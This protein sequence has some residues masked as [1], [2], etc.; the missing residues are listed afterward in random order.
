MR[1]LLFPQLPQSCAT[2]HCFVFRK[3]STYVF[4]QDPSGRKIRPV[5]TVSELS[6]A[7]PNGLDRQLARFLAEEDVERAMVLQQG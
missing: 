2:A 7:A 4:D 6:F 1:T 5:E 3:P